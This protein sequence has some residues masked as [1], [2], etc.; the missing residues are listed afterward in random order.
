MGNA[1]SKNII[2]NVM[3]VKKLDD[4]SLDSTGG[5]TLSLPPVV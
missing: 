4:S 5:L 2:R 1:D 3:R